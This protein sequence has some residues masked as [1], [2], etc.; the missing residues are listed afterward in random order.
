MT[1]HFLLL[2]QVHY[3][4]HIRVCTSVAWLWSSLCFITLGRTKYSRPFYGSKA[5]NCASVFYP[6][7]CIRRMKQ[8]HLWFS[9]DFQSLCVFFIMS[10]T[11]T[12]QLSLHMKQHRWDYRFSL[13]PKARPSF[14]T[15]MGNRL[16]NHLSFQY[17]WISFSIF[18]F[19]PSNSQSNNLISGCSL[20]IILPEIKED[21]NRESSQKRS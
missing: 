12:Q 8:I 15:R 6:W 11:G 16:L 13:Q 7:V 1:C 21:I 4:L 10:V 14:R 2:L 17:H 9:H 18:Y 20:Q 3:F 5:V 19:L